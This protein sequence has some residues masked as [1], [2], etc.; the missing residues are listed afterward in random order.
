MADVFTP[1]NTQE[2]FDKAVEEQLKADRVAIEKKYAGFADYKAK[3]DKYDTD[4]AA[5]DK[6]IADRD[7]KISSYETQATK[8]KIAKE[9][10]LPADL[11]DR[12]SGDTEEAMREDAAALSKLIG[13]AHYEPLADTNPA[14]DNNKGAEEAGYRSLLA[15]LKGE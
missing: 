7:A 3:A 11:A 14:G 10:G 13:G 4:M 1:I 6:E 5:K 12:I 2:E 9:T 8:A 15:G